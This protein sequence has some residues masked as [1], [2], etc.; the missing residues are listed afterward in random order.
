MIMLFLVLVI[1]LLGV[2]LVTKPLRQE[3]KMRLGDPE[4][5]TQPNRPT[6]PEAPQYPD[7]GIDG[8]RWIKM[9]VR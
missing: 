9:A 2:V 6:Q 8:M 7:V 5:P 1:V 3:E 4:L